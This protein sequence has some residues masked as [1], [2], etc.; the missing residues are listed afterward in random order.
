MLLLQKGASDF[1]YLAELVKALVELSAQERATPSLEN[2]LQ[3]PT[4]VS[5]S[6]ASEGL[7]AP[8]VQSIRMKTAS[9]EVTSANVTV[10]NNPNAL[11]SG[12]SSTTTASSTSDTSTSTISSTSSATN[13]STALIN[14]SSIPTKIQTKQTECKYMLFFLARL[15]KNIFS[16][17]V[18]HQKLH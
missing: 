12:M 15:A 11:A 14:Q 4:V 13:P 17:L 6:S 16:F 7:D 3:L 10:E 5:P 18:C 9:K 8:E 1:C 2:A